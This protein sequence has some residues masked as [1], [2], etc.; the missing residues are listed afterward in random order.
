M[1]ISQYMLLQGL[2]W[3][4]GYDHEAV[5][6]TDAMAALE[7]IES[8]ISDSRSDIVYEILKLVTFFNS[9]YITCDFV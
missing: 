6:F 3:V 5:V 4:N 2:R 8:G 9:Q 7:A 1:T